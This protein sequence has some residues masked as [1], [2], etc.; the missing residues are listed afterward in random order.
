M[1]DSMRALVYAALRTLEIREVP[2]PILAIGEVKVK[3]TATGICGSDLHGFQGHSARRQP[4]LTLG[5]ESVGVV[6]SGDPRLEGLRVSVNPLI[7]CGICAACRAGRQNNCTSWRLLGMDQT[8]GGFGEFVTVPLRNVHPIPDTCSDAEAVLV[9]P[10]AN[11]FHLLSMAPN[12]AGL[13]PTI[14]IVGGGTLGACILSVALARGFQVIAV[15]EPN[16][17]R[18]QVATALGAKL[19]LDPRGND[20]AATVMEMTGGLGVAAAVDAVGSSLT[21]NTA[22]AMLAK[23]GTALLL[24]LD[25]GPTTFD[26][27]DLIRREIR[28]QTS[29]AYT[30]QNYTEALNF[31]LQKKVDFSRWTETVPLAEGQSAF[32]RLISSPGDRIKIALTLD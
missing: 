9:E 18:A 2:E 15:S 20:V 24:G 31:V 11:A 22:V 12:N 13:T 17:L 27:F 1:D 28:L 29:Y 7:T 6:V 14:A 5:H 21:R 4:G 3:V 19:V 23:G 32:E 10:L 25:E 30:E 8:N 16:Q 26:F